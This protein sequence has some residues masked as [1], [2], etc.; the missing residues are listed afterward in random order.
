MSDPA[1]SSHKPGNGRSLAAMLAGSVAVLGALVTQLSDAPWWITVCLTVS[2]TIL[3]V[4]Y[5]ITSA[6]GERPPP[7]TNAGPDVK[8]LVAA[9]REPY[10]HT[11]TRPPPGGTLETTVVER[12]PHRTPEP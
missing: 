9:V 6:W 3:G 5:M 1:S 7:T 10:S 8:A 4:V 11:D 12:R 2:A